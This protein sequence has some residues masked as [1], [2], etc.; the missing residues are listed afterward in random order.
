[1]TA[2][3]ERRPGTPQV[4]N[5]YY[6]EEPPPV[7]AEPPATKQFMVICDEGWRSSIVCGGMYEWAA[8]W[9]VDRI[10]GQ[11]YPGERS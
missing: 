5:Y 1:M 4:P 8:K 11:P 2:P 6:M 7:G 3:E 9:L 10:Q